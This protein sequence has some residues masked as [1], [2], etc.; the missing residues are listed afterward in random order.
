M[1]VSDGTFLEALRAE[2]SDPR[3]EVRCQALDALRARAAEFGPPEL[4][5]L[6][7]LLLPL[8]EEDTWGVRSAA[9]RA[10]GALDAGSSQVARA[11]VSRALEDPHLWVRHAALDALE[12][13]AYPSEWLEAPFRVAIQDASA[14]ARRLYVLRAVNRLR[15]F[16]EPLL[17]RIEDALGDA[18][19]AVREAA[20]RALGG[21]RRASPR[22]MQRVAEVLRDPDPVVREAAC[23]ALARLDPL[24]DAASAALA[25]TAQDPEP[26]VRI[27]CA[28]ALVQLSSPAHTHVL[29]ALLVDTDQRVREAAVVAMGGAPQYNLTPAQWLEYIEDPSATVRQAVESVLVDSARADASLDPLLVS[30][31]TQ[32]TSWRKPVS[33]AR[34]LVRTGVHDV[35]TLQSLLST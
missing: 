4:P 28:R 12:K 20:L 10:L 16:S 13:R 9:A 23:E 6:V 15:L 31:L 1:S 29:R 25:Q 32:R 17:E 7:A 26:Q 14:S 18:D 34:V 11:L 24:D 2:L 27:A 22:R 8:L 30:T 21:T 5:H 33:A 3:F 19:W 35:A